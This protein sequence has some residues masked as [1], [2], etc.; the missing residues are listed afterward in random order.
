M[1]SAT[2]A[3]CDS[4][5]WHQLTSPDNNGKG[6]IS[7]LH[8]AQGCTSPL[9]QRQ[10]QSSSKGKVKME[11]TL[12]SRS[13]PL[14]NLI[15]PPLPISSFCLAQRTSCPPFPRPREENKGAL[16]LRFLCLLLS[17]MG[18]SPC[19]L[20]H[21]RSESFASRHLDTPGLLRGRPVQCLNNLSEAPNH[22][23]ISS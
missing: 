23:H 16:S 2:A 10:L 3:E 18:Q 21:F 4:A 13:P 12:C 20:L 9:S 1:S 15:S 8:V 19:C 6:L 5:S 11:I 14:M 7:M 17:A 22:G